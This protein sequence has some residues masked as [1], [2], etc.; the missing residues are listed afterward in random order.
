VKPRRA[1]RVYLPSPAIAHREIEGQILLLLPDDSE[2]YT[3]N[4]AA[5]FIWRGLVRR[6]GLRRIVDELAREFGIDRERA[7]ADVMKFVGDMESKGVLT[8]RK[9]AK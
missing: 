4:T 7:E 6:R 1:N 9:V 5:S 3:F 8:R 2:I